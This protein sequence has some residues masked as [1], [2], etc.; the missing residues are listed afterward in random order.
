LNVLYSFVSG[1][2]DATFPMYGAPVIDTAKNLYG[3]SMAGG[4]NGDGAVWEL[5]YS[6]ATK[7]YTEQ[8]IDSFNT[9]SE[10]SA[11]ANW[12]LVYS[13][14]KLFGTTGGWNSPGQGGSV[15]ELIYVKPTATAPG[16]WQE[17]DIYDFPA[18]V[19][20]G[21]GWNQLI[22]DSKGNFYG[23]LP[24]L[25]VGASPYGSVFEVSPSEQ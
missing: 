8:V 4:A 5:V 7:T 16:G 19:G 21:P 15:F 24:G 14:G 10:E 1:T 20:F 3:T 22:L 23:M 12:G 13:A 17:V 6:A 18:S 11:G 9:N 2:T 25:E